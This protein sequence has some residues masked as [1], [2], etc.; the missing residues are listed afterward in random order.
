MKN[1]DEDDEVVAVSNEKRPVPVKIHDELLIEVRGRSCNRP[2]LFS[3]KQQSINQNDVFLL[4]KF[5][6]FFD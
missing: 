4:A 5:L 2:L 6:N 3:P 1:A